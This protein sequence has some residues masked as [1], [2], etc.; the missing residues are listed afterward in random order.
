MLFVASTLTGCGNFF[1]KITTTT[2]PTTPTTTDDY[3]YVANSSTA[4]DTLAGY[5]LA[6]G[7][8]TAVASSP[9]LVGAVPSVLAITPSNSFVFVGSEFGGIYAYAIGST[10]GL[11]IG[12]TGLVSS[13]SATSLAVDSTGNWLL[14]LQ[15]AGTAPLLTVFAIDTS[16]GALTTQGSVSLDPGASGSLLFVPGTSLVYA[17]LGTG[18]VD[19]LTFDSS[20]GAITKLS[21]LLS[22]T[23]SGYSDQH[24]AS[25]PAGT[26]LFVTETGI[27]GVRSFSINSSTGVLTELAGSPNSTGLGTGAVAVDST[28]SFVYVANSAANTISAFS[29]S[30]AGALT[31]ISG[32]PFATGSSPYAMVEDKSKGYLAVT[33]SG[34]TPDLELFPIASSG[35]LGTPITQATGTTSPAGATAIVASN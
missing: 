8:L 7:E 27:L 22:P 31:A 16:T 11:T 26:F 21:V 5:S 25:N 10:G 33:C 17:T 3:L 13:V 35:A 4:L 20:T 2:S 14:A 23:R 12:S 29:L 28:G 30:T 24:L 9:Y 34:G 18:G 1:A 32:S 6:S 19:A 15:S